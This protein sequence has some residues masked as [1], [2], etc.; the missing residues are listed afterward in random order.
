M[1][2][3][4][5]PTFPMQTNIGPRR[6][7]PM[8]G[9]EHWLYRHWYEA[10]RED[11]DWPEVYTYTDS[12]SYQPG[13]EVR[14]HA[15]TTAK[16]WSLKV[17]RDTGRELILIHSAEDIAGAFTAMPGEA[18][19]V[20][21]GWPVAHKWRLPADLRSGFYRVASTCMRKDGSRFVQHHFF[22]VRPTA[23]TRQAKVLLLLPTGTWTAYNDWGGAN[24]Y[25]GNAG[26]TGDQ[27][28]P[29]V[30]LERPWTR[31]LVWLP[32]GAPRICTTPP[33]ELGDLPRYP[34]KEWAYANGFGAYYAASGWAQYDRHFVR[35][36]EQ[37]GYA[38]DIITQTDLHYHPEVLEGYRCVVIVGHDE[39]W[40]YAMR[41]SLERYMEA[42]GRVARF[43]ANFM[44]QIRLEE[45]G[46]RQ[47]C[48][49]FRASETDPIRGTPESHLLT[50]G[51]EDPKV[52][53]PGA[54]TFGVNGFE[55]LYASWGGFAPRGQRGFTV[56]RP[57]H[58]VF[59]KTDL[60]YGDIFGAEARIFT[61][62]VDGLDYTFHDGL[63]YPT[64]RD[65]ADTSI[66]ILAMAPAVLGEEPRQHEGHR[67]Y[68]ADNDLNG[69]VKLMTGGTLPPEALDRYRY[70]SGMVVHMAKGKG[71]VV[72]AATCEW[73]MGLKRAC[74]FTQQIT[75]NV[76]DRFSAG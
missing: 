17:E 29:V 65:G 76:L 66:Q 15:S 64:G 18:Y 44:W 56:Y 32:E 43:G 37:E 20:G 24:H 59:D 19:R 27:P 7:A 38:L 60:Y 48:Y 55:G 26:P 52:A 10:P 22:V 2:S 42:G 4:T 68:I 23:Q 33:P 8:H 25:T 62:E 14:F 50:S 74:P 40:S 9:D 69:M 67:Y 75:R 46:R 16:T 28:A 63:P 34:Q 45:E 73:V 30:S 1:A 57:R 41:R 13:D 31:G 36:A 12:I 70:G 71:E 3:M 21:C 35:W 39:Y 5:D 51:W 49:K 72:S 53:W 54:S 61:Y 47:V 6:S 58:W 11:P